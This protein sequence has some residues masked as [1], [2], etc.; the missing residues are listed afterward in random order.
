MAVTLGDMKGRISQLLQGYTR[1]QEQI[2]WL[3]QAMTATDTSFLVDIGTSTSVT[4]GLVEIEDELLLVNNFNTQTGT[5]NVSAGA[6]GRGRENT[7]PAFHDL[8]SIVTMD[9]SYPRQRITEAFDLY[10]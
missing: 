6:N 10:R 5:V 4:R 8:N 3:A 7:T 1:N 9:P 2:T